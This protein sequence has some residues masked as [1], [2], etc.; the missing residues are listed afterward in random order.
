MKTMEAGAD[1]AVIARYINEAE[2]ER[3]AAEAPLAVVDEDRP[4][5]AA[6]LLAAIDE[7]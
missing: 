3:R 5:T 4:P 1:P 6:E 7:L 2:A